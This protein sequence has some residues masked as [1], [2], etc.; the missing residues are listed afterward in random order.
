MV[1]CLADL[2]YLITGAGKV[3]QEDLSWPVI[4]VSQCP[5]TTDK[6]FRFHD[7][8]LMKVIRDDK[9]TTVLVPCSKTRP[10]FHRVEKRP[11]FPLSGG[12]LMPP[13]FRKL[14]TLPKG[15]F[16]S[17]I[18]RRRHPWGDLLPEKR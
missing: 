2:I 4:L 14:G 16:T 6:Y 11:S 18:S 5:G 17:H 13:Q 12:E 1:G 3:D 10:A 7:Q 9:G 8:G 15:S